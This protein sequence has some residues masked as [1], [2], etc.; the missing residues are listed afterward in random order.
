MFVDTHA[1]LFYNNFED[2]LFEVVKRAREA[3]VDYMLVP[4][5]DLKT[6]QQVIELCER[7]DFIY[8]AVGV[9][10]HDSKEWDDSF[11]Q[12]VEELAKH[13][14]IVAIGEIGLDYFYDFSPKE[15]QI[16][17]FKDQIELALKLNLPVIIHNRDSDTDMMEIIKSYAGSGLRAQFHCYNASLEDARALVAMHHYISFT[18][19]IT[20]KKFDSLREIAAAIPLENIMIET[21]SPFMTPVPYRGKRNEP[22]YVKYV[23]EKLAELHK[24]S[25]EEV[26][27]IT[28]L[29]AFKMFGIGKNKDTIHTYKIHNSL[30]INITN[31]CN[32]DCIFCHRKENPV[33]HGYNLKMKHSDEPGADVY[34]SEIGDPAAYDEIV[35]C[36]FGEPTI[37]W[38]VVKKI[39][40]YVKDC[41]GNTRLNTNGHGSYINKKNI[42]PELKGLIDTV[43]ISLNSFDPKQYAEIMKVD[44]R[45]FNEMVTFAKEAK[46]YAG[47]VVL[48]IVAIDDVEIEKARTIVEDKI[49]V[50]FRVREYF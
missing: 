19:N 18:G 16:K 5:T 15:K 31:R 13:P 47:K 50:E 21:D 38:G 7:Y 41:G 29:N 30:Y 48:S 11:I 9:H 17:A 14:K 20:F 33:V 6:A 43:S 2:D 25:V 23:A 35:F 22:A 1:H 46:M 4:A 28:S 8:G 37:R 45:L 26:G 39:A 24:I 34:I 12:T 27:R 40:K 10:P 49:G 3:G 42:T 32:A 36:G 44:K